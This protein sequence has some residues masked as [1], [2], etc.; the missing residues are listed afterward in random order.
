M[1]I[2]WGNLFNYNNESSNNQQTIIE[3]FLKYW[4]TNNEIPKK[5][6][7]ELFAMRQKIL[8]L[9]LKEELRAKILAIGIDDLLR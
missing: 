9:R 8:T 2:L 6:G 4:N 5:K 1:D 7:S 3:L